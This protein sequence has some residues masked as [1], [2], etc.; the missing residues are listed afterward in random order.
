MVDNGLA[1]D[2]HGRKQEYRDYFGCRVCFASYPS[3]I[4]FSADILDRP[5]PQS[6]PETSLYFRQQCHMLIAK[7]SSQSHFIDDLR[8]LI[9]ARPGYFPDIDSLA[10]KLHMSTRTL[11]R[12]LKAEGSSYRQL[13]E[14]IR[15]ELAREYLKE[16]ELPLDEISF[17]LGYTEP[18]TFSH[19]FRR[20]SGQP[21]SVYRKNR[22][23]H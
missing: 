18:G 12:R 20:W 13:L 4:I 7:L 17:L 9:L 15:F 1:H 2:G 14:E 3:Q 10:E 11:R 23:S 22:A 21:P 16:T 6:D 5:L 19:A 8:M